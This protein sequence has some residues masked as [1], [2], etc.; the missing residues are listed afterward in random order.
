MAQGH[1]LSGGYTKAIDRITDP[2]RI[3]ALLERLRVNRCLLTV[4]PDES[5][6]AYNSALLEIH[7]QQGYLVLDELNPKDGHQRLVA[8]RRLKVQA[9]LKGVELNFATDLES[10]GQHLGFWFYRVALPLSLNYHQRRRHYRAKIGLSRHIPVTLR[11]P[12]AESVNGRLRDISVGGIGANFP[13][14]FPESLA[15]SDHALECVIA[16]P[17]GKDIVCHVMICFVNRSL[18][19]NSRVVGARF[20]ELGAAQQKTVAEFV[21]ALD[22]ELMKKLHRN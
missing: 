21:V 9:W 3:A 5:G 4:L 18:Q 2:V 15:G 20:V 11:L 19:D 7:P 13:P 8:S 12:N 22:R 16:L 6:E 17:R 10:V 1:S 14:T